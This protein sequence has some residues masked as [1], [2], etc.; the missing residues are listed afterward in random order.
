M[1]AYVSYH[2]LMKSLVTAYAVRICVAYRFPHGDSQNSLIAL[3]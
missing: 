1:A 3:I 2:L